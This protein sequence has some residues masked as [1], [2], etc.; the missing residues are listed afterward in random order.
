MDAQRTFVSSSS[1][2]SGGTTRVDPWLWLPPP[3]ALLAGCSDDI[4]EAIEAAAP[5]PPSCSRLL[6]PPPPPPPPVMGAVEP[7]MCTSHSRLRVRAQ[8]AMWRQ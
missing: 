2:W 7:P 4:I 8:P 6:L 1:F 3:A 5:L